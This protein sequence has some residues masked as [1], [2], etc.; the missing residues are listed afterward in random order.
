[1]EILMPLEARTAV[2][3]GATGELGSVLARKL[4]RQNV[5]LAL[6]ARDSD[7]L[8]KL[9]A[10][11]ALPPERLLLQAVDLVD[12]AATQAAANAIAGHFGRVDI[13]VHLVGGWSGGKTLLETPAID[14]ELM[15][16]QHVWS[17]FNVAQAFIPHMVRGGW[18]R[19]VT[20]S[21]PSAVRPGAKGGSYAVG[22]AGQDTLMLVLSQELKG[23]GVTANLIQVNQIDVKREKV[24]EPNSK[25]ASWTTPEEIMATI[26][27]LLSDE[28][29][30]INGTKIPLF[31]SYA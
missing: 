20:V 28:A 5:N 3:T 27:F 14:L 22:K 24:S 7:K 17:T 19:I 30:T 15:L 8:A 11:L 31:G 26:L 25:N 1:M 23:T 4:A 2:I 12:Q 6:L 29:G 16:S 18:G 21:S 10:S 9:K 13:C